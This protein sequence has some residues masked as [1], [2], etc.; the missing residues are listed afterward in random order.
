MTK[1]YSFHTLNVDIHVT[2][3]KSLTDTVSANIE[4]SIIDSTMSRELVPYNPPVQQPIF[5]PASPALTTQP[6]AAILSPIQEET[7]PPGPPTPVAKA[8]ILSPVQEET[9]T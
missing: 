6:K 2:T 4:S 7:T 9:T 5:H 8:T 3:G 1:D